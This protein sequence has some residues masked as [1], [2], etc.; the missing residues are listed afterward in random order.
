VDEADPRVQLRVTG[1]SLLQT[2][3]VN[4]HHAHVSAV[5]EVTYLFKARR[6]QT[7][8]F[9]N[10]KQIGRPAGHGCIWIAVPRGA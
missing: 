3:H 8:G 1:E 5:V 2:R 6:F 7:V 4:Q 9:V 10:H